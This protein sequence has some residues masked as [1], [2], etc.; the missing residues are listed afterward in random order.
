MEIDEKEFENNDESFIYENNSLLKDIKDQDQSH[1]DNDVNFL[2]NETLQEEDMDY[3]NSIRKNFLDQNSSNNCLNKTFMLPQKK[4]FFNVSSSQTKQAYKNSNNM[5]QIHTTILNNTTLLNSSLNGSLIE[6]KNSSLNQTTVTS[7]LK[8]KGRKKVLLEGVKTEVLEKAFLREFKQWLKQT[9][10]FRMIYDQFSP[11]EKLFWNEFIN[12]NAPPFLF[13]INNRKQEFKSYSKQLMRF[14]FSYGSSRYLYDLFI[15]ERDHDVVNKIFGKKSK[16]MFDNKLMV[17]YSIYGGN[18][19]KIYSPDFEIEEL[20]DKYVSALSNPSVKQSSS[21]QIL[22]FSSKRL[23]NLTST[24]KDQT[25]T[26]NNSNLCSQSNYSI[27]KDKSYS[28]F[29]GGMSFAF[30]VKSPFER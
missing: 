5:S 2:H 25:S 7:S 1:Y 13:T 15:K 14:L 12:N 8:N 6:N 3:I 9:N 10:Y 20:E 16:V 21:S 4:R 29:E 22:S 19:H 27:N 23:S 28:S 18:L 24:T 30:L 17:Y 11:E 26:Y